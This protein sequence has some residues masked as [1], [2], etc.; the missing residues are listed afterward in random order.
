MERISP[1]QPGVIPEPA[2]RTTPPSTP[3]APAVAEGEIAQ[4][5]DVQV[6]ST[7]AQTAVPPAVA[8]PQDLKALSAAVASG[9]YP[10]D[11]KAIAKALLAA[12]TGPES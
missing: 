12:F 4:H 7:G 5:P 10:V 9:Q 8:S 6:G 2:A 3:P 11:P 1:L